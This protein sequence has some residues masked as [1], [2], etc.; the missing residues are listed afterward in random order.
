MRKA[1]LVTIAIL[2][3]TFTFSQGDIKSF[4]KQSKGK[5]VI[6]LDRDSIT[7][8]YD[9]DDGY[10]DSVLIIKFRGKDY[11]I[12]IDERY[13]KK[14]HI[15][16]YAKERFNEIR[17]SEDNIINGKVLYTMDF[18]SKK[19]L[20]LKNITD[21]KDL[22]YIVYKSYNNEYFDNPNI[23]KEKELFIKLIN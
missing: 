10:G 14:N 18:F 6:E 8:E 19:D 20:N 7:L 5:D 13:Y 22:D 21:I 1:T 23:G 9:E 4:K 12:F 17:M 11:I 16:N 3:T 2:F 15:T